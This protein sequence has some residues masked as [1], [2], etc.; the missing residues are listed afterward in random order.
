[1]K[2]FLSLVLALVMTM[3]LVTISAGAKD[4]TDDSKINY[5]EAVDVMSAVKVIDGYADGS[6]NPQGSLTRGAAA[7]I[8]CNLI[9]GPTTAAALSADTA[10]YKDVPV[11]H[12]FAGYIAYCQQQ[13][14]ISG[15]ADGTFRP[16]ATLTNYAFLKML[17]GAL[18]YDSNIEGYVGDNWSIAVAKRA[19]NIGLTKGLDGT[20]VGTDYATREQACLYALNTLQATM[21][22]YSTTVTA[23]VNGAQV[24]VGNSV[25][26]ELDWDIASK[27]DGNIKDDEYVQFAEK[28]FTNLELEIGNGI[29]GRPANTWKLKK[30]E[31]GTYTSI[32][33]TYVY[34]ET[35]EEKD[36]YKD[37][38][39]AVCDTSKDG[40]DWTAFINGVEEEPEDLKVPASKS[41]DDYKYTGDGAVT[42][43]YVDV[44][45]ETVTVV[46]INYYIGQVTK[47][48]DTDD[49]ETITVK[50]LSTEPELD[51]NTFVA[52]GYE[53]DDYVVFT[54]DFDDDEDDY[55]IG[56]V[57]EP[58]TATGD[59]VRVETD[60]DSK[61][62]YIKLADG[63][64][65]NYSESLTHN[66]Y[67]LDDAAKVQHPDLNKEYILYMDPNGFVLGFEPAEDKVDQY[68]YVQDSDEEMKDWVAKVVLTDA[69]NP[70][71]DLKEKLKDYKDQIVKYVDEDL[72]VEAEAMGKGDKQIALAEKI[73]W[74]ENQEGDKDGYSKD[75]RTSIDNRIWKYSASDKG[76]YTLTWVEN[77]VLGAKKDGK[78]TAEINNGKAY[79][80]EGGD[81]LIVDR[82]TIFVDV[83]GEKSYVG[84]KEVPNVD[85]AL[86]AC[87]V[88]D[89]LIAEVVFI[90]KGNVYDENATYFV[91]ADDDR[92][93]GDYDDED[94]YWE[95]LN[96]YVDGEKVKDFCVTY[97]AVKELTGSAKNQLSLGT[98]YKATKT[99]ED[100][101]YIDEIE[102]I[103]DE[104]GVYDADS[105]K[106]Y[107]TV[108]AKENADGKIIGEA[109]GDNAFWITTADEKEVKFDTDEETVYVT[110]REVKTLDSKGKYETEWK[111]ADGDIEDLKKIDPD[112]KFTYS[113]KKVHVAKKTNDETARLVYIF[114]TE[115]EIGETKTLTFNADSNVSKITV[116]G[117]D[118]DENGKVEAA[119]GQDAVITVETKAGY[120]VSKV[121]VDGKEIEADKDGTYTIPELTKNT[122]VK[123]ETREYA[124]GVVTVEDEAGI[125]IVTV[126]GKRVTG[127]SEK[128]EGEVTIKVQQKANADKIGS[129]V[130]DDVAVEVGETYTTTMPAT[131]I[132]VTVNKAEEVKDTVVTVKATNAVVIVGGVEK[133]DNA[134]MTG[135]QAGDRVQIEVKAEGLADADAPTAKYNDQAVALNAAGKATITIVEGPS[136][137]E[138]ACANKEYTVNFKSHAPS[139]WKVNP[140]S[141]KGE[142]GD[143]VEVTL[144]KEA[145]DFDADSFKVTVGGTAQTI[146]SSV[147]GVAPVAAGYAEVSGVTADNFD[148]KLAECGKLYIEVDGN[149]VAVVQFVTGKTYYKATP[150]SEGT[151]PSFTVEYEITGLE[152]GDVEL[153]IERK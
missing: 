114:W 28:Y 15:Y 113:A 143:K 69:T 59:V 142:K 119:K 102:K 64:K 95:Y 107:G 90:L 127:T 24:T 101:K 30:S 88:N 21:V 78:F 129:I 134:K 37:L 35:T 145:D 98:L 83:N 1:M 132:T 118:W 42:E 153:K 13:G 48:K 112:N 96:A 43:I 147:N 49:G 46:E 44:D 138:I 62:A 19:L 36:V 123:V 47:V 29:Y 41:D 139:A 92:E 111:I 65:Y 7:K 57:I 108:T 133:G 128:I 66:A 80:S 53:E 99:I 33:P 141:V 150:A 82:K 38:G 51:V 74:I 75:G 3:S 144:T 148:A 31:I 61:N 86:L 97:D 9:L 40:Y 85:N 54:V 8:I 77:V 39:K 122:K 149:K 63:E 93:S 124:A 130:I 14:I 20:L 23:N 131:G 26:K 2:K 84:Y 73:Q 105:A 89:D 81:H 60:K 146:K 104:A 126:N 151:A 27:T 76:V 110:V 50:A 135:Y 120:A 4:F 125:A 17:L 71:V 115:T 6:F 55:V 12:T 140:A 5:E 70:K 117:V 109:V 91:L 22:D 136:T 94:Y 121:T 34:T 45:R 11:N 16:A 137:L 106:R 87:V 58:E 10:P 32:D 79:I 100:G 152:S 68:L 72:G 52:D 103:S 67:D 116:N 56:E 25:A 18:G